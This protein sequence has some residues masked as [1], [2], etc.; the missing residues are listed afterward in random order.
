MDRTDVK[1][2]GAYFND[3]FVKLSIVE[4]LGQLFNRAMVDVEVGKH[5]TPAIVAYKDYYKKYIVQVAI[6]VS[7]IWN[8]L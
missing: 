2:D 3:Y 7:L 4:R 5:G 6:V 8:K 1:Y